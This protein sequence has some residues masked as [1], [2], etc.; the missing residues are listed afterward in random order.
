MVAAHRQAARVGAVAAARR[1]K[2]SIAYTFSGSTK[3]AGITDVAMGSFAPTTTSVS[4]GV[5]REDG[6]LGGVDG[7]YHTAAVWGEQMATDLYSSQVTNGGLNTSNRGVG[8]GLSTANGSKIVA[9]VMRGNTDPATLITWIS[10]T[11]SQ[12]AA[13]AGLYAT[14][15]QTISIVPSLSAGIWTFTA[16]KNG[17]PTG[18]SWTDSGAVFGTP[19]RYPCAVFNHLYSFGQYSSPG[20]SAYAAA[21]L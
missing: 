14:A 2:R 12:R 19:G 20:V 21:D 5:I 8:A 11:L 18:L 3:P 1:Q 15:G 7:S 13:L 10:G 9:V 6:S 4:G 17:S 16:Y